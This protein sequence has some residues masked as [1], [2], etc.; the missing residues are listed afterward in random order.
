MAERQLGDESGERR[1]SR[2]ETRIVFVADVDVA[3]NDEQRVGAQELDASDVVVD[4]VVEIADE[5]AALEHDALR[6][7]PHLRRADGDD[8]A[9]IRAGGFVA[10]M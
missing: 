4:A 7:R 6:A 1:R 10:Q 8:A 9:G 5:R 3:R 2:R